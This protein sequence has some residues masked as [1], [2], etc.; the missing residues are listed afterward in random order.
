MVNGQGSYLMIQG[1]RVEAGNWVVD[2]KGAS[3]GQDLSL[4]KRTKFCLGWGSDLRRR[5]QG[6]VHLGY[7]STPKIRL[8]AGL[9]GVG[10]KVRA[11]S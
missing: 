11:V 3:A 9:A 6:F 7:C 4:E 1:A 10:S 5:P 2:A 8:Q